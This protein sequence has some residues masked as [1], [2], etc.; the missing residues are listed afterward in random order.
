MV[1]VVKVCTKHG[2]LT[3]KDVYE[4]R[5][6]N[7][8]TFRLRCKQCRRTYEDKNKEARLEYSRNYEKNKR[9][10]PNDY[11]EKTGKVI[12]REWRRANADLVNE[13]VAA[14]RKEDPERF[15]Q[16]DRDWRANNIMYAR[17][18]DVIKKHKMSYDEYKWMFERQDGVCAICKKP[19]KRK[20]RTD[21][22]ICRLAIDHHHDTGKIRELLC[23]A[24]NQVIGHSYENIELLQSAI[25][26]LKKHQE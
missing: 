11:Y 19:E 13:R 24:C 9:N 20:S 22:Q 3:I 21:G 25:E 5:D 17:E 23:H 7:G 1:E 8:I 16:Y 6:K 26:Y 14:A 18:R 12:S 4:E 10:R 2:D 15:R